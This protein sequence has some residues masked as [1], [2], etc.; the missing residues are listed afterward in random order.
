M[1]LI[2]QPIDRRA[3]LTA[4]EFRA[5]YWQPE[6]PV[7]LTD[8]ASRWRA[9]TR[10]QPDELV[11]NYGDRPIRAYS[12]PQA[13]YTA[14]GRYRVDTTL[15]KVISDADP[16]TFISSEVLHECPY[17][18]E[19][20]AVPHLFPTEA[21]TD[22]AFFWVQPK[23]TRTGLH[24]DTYNSVLTVV[25]GEKRVLLFAPDQYDK[26][27]PCTVTGSKDFTR[28][29]WSNVDIFAP[30]Y[31]KFPR[32]RDAEY[33]EVIVRAGETVIF[34][35]HWWHAVENRGTPTI[36]VSF[37]A[38]KQGKPEPWFYVDRRTIIGLAVRAGLLG[39]G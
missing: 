1:K 26:L 24:W 23:G 25:H 21:T 22:H 10:W 17:L 34:P 15:G 31:E 12:H 36:S 28:A 2:E 3:G 11:R 30:D 7:V 16:R 6:Q 8:Q 9:M 32:L 29:S 27:Y 19:D 4:E 13:L 33:H 39:T 20:F 14:W 38:L 35:G 5:A 18:I 37:F